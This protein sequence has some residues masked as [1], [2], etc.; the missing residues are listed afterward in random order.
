MNSHFLSK[1]QYHRFHPLVNRIVFGKL[2]GKAKVFLLV[3]HQC[4][5]LLQKA[6][7]DEPSHVLRVE[8][9]PDV[10]IELCNLLCTF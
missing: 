8:V 6:F 7:D 10:L 9:T 4:L 2:G 5:P 3:L 1:V